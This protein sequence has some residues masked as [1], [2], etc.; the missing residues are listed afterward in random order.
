MKRRWFPALFI[1]ISALGL[2][3]VPAKA[4]SQYPVSTVRLVTHSSAGGGTDVFL[5]RLATHL[6][7][8]M[9]VNFVVE[10]ITGAGGARAMAA[11]AASPKDGGMFYGTT[12]TYVITSLL[13]DLQVGYDDL[14]PIVNMFYD[15]QI[16][17]VRTESPYQN[18]LDIIEDAQARPSQ[19]VAA[20]STPA[21]QDRQI[22]EQF[23]AI[24][25]TDVIVL[26]HD[27][28]G[29]VLLNVLNG[30]ADFG[31][32]E[33]AEMRGQIDA[34]QMR[35]ITSYTEERVP[36]LGDVPTAREQGIDLVVRKFRGIAGPK[37]LPPEIIAAW[38]EGI[39]AL[40]ENPDFKAWYEGEGVQYAYMGNE[41]ARE[42]TAQFA[43]E[44]EAFF[45]EYNIIE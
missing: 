7:S 19:V 1:A 24:T 35:V 23:K 30:T 3:M 21:S 17:F 20:V 37:D 32:G 8:I 5:R 9:G 39:Q 44:I 27:G 4:Q 36:V 31:I 38:E 26:T 41:E 18:L 6:D 43:E 10:N 34:G 28:G 29:E 2:T 11:I 15:P 25:D 45:R 14:D 40:L 13:S 33:I 22:M 42:M 12:P 16:V